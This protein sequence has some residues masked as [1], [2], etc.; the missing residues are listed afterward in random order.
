MCGIVAYY[1]TSKK[2][3]TKR[4]LASLNTLVHRGP[5]ATTHWFDN[6]HQIALGHT[7]LS[8][9]DLDTGFQPLHSVDGTIHAVVNGEFY[10]FEEIRAR[11][12]QNGYQFKTHS[13]SEIL[14]ALYQ[15]YGVDCMN[16]LKSL[17]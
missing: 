10:Q 2:L 9:I 14:I 17:D 1:S 12:Q 8:I 7:R 5:D 15:E 6:K 3:N 4:L 11:L 16:K 13:D